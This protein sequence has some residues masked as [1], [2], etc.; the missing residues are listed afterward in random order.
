MKKKLGIAG[1]IIICFCLSLG[2]C[3][4][5]A[6]SP[7]ESTVQ[8][9][10]TT[11]ESTLK[12]EAEAETVMEAETEFAPFTVTDM[13]G[14]EITIEA[15]I[16]KAYASNL[17]GIL[18]LKT[19]APEVIAGYTNPVSESEKEFIPEKYQQLPYLGG[20]CS[21]NPTANIEEMVGKDIDV[22]FVTA[23]VNK[24]MKE[25]AGNI[26]SQTGI[27]TVMV[28]YDLTQLEEAYAL[29]GKVL[30][31]E[32]RAK[33]LGH[34]CTTELD[35]V[36]EK[37]EKVPDKDKVRIYY[38][39]GDDGLKTDPSGSMHTQVFDFLGVTNVADVAENSTNGIK[40]QSSVSLEQVMSWNPQVII[41]NSTY[42]KAD[43]QKAVKEILN[44]PNWSNIDAVK[45]KKVYL[46]PSLPNNWIDRA[47]SVNRVLGVKWL[48]NLLYPDY[49][50]YDIKK[51]TKEFFQLFYELD[52]T[53]EQIDKIL[54]LTES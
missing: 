19:L 1:L 51:E 9:A 39:E 15:P 40:G 22:I 50:D 43:P 49:M 54:L 30:G 34:Y 41:R 4:K 25:L 10:D 32:D 3:K 24:K 28:S 8:A 14:R 20:W 47:P 18:F 29:M 26:Q 13:G 16:K 48:A 6:D 11:P 5:E 23:A 38:A 37:L 46:T 31:K 12:T 44:N 27:P 33:K 36:K 7:V 35:Q 21:P 52:L 45:N 2:A 42:T 17:I 53:D